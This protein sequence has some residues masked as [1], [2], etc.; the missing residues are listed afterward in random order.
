[1]SHEIQRALP[2][3]ALGVFD[4]GGKRGEKEGIFPQMLAERL[5]RKEKKSEGSKKSP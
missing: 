3:K 5:A 1:M 4:Y 2:V